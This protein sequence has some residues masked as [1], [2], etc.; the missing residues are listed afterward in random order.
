MNTNLNDTTPAATT[1]RTNVTWQKDGSGN[2]S[3]SVPTGGTGTVTSV[4]L[5]V[6][7]EFS[8]AG[9]P[10]TTSGTLAVTKATQTANTVFAGP[11][12]G[13]AAA[14][15][16][17]A[18]VPADLPLASSSAFGAVKVD[19]T[20][21]TAA[22]GVISVAGSGGTGLIGTANFN[23]NGSISNAHYGG[24]ISSVTFVSTGKYTVNFSSTQSDF[25][26][27]LCASDDNV[28]ATLTEISGTPDFHAGVSSFNIITAGLTG[29][30]AS[31]AARNSSSITVAIFK[32]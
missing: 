31:V 12:T 13:S 2:V 20:S 1:G 26:V 8:V 32:L 29:T 15:A 19:G 17:R 9:S 27:A 16:F 23:G 25:S 24:V 10:V 21:I 11:T 3:A 7:A 18:V 6:P 22:S 5:T 30:P 28:A 14:P 4:A